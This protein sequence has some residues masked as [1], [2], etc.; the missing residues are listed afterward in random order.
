ML[1]KGFKRVI[2]AVLCLSLALCVFPAPGALASEYNPEHPETL[3]ARHIRGEAAIVMEADTGE[4]LFE[5]NADE[6][7]PPASTTKI[8]TAL[9]ALTMADPNDV[10]TV[11]EYA[12]SL[13]PEQHSLIG[14]KAG[15]QVPMGVL[16]QA[17]MVASGNDGAIAVA[18]HISG[19]E[20]AFVALMNE[21]AARYGCTAPFQQL[22]RLS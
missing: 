7:R 11:S 13:D 5:K 3:T 14:L 21:A 4:V 2:P 1:R 18:E 9:L 12:A 10:V 22:P 8:I 6:Y 16:V 19:S 15:E 20:P 17:M